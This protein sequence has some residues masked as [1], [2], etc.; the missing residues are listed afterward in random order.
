MKTVREMCP[1]MCRILK[2]YQSTADQTLRIWRYF[3]VEYISRNSFGQE[4]L[5]SIS[6]IQISRSSDIV[7]LKRK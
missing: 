5:I 4:S 1:E 3:R 6:R 7:L 2:E